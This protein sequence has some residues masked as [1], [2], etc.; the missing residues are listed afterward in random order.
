MLSE[1]LITNIALKS[2]TAI[3][4]LLLFAALTSKVQELSTLP[5]PQPLPSP[6]AAAVR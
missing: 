2:I 3:A 5:A 6:M 1:N 4:G